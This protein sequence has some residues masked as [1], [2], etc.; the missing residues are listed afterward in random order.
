MQASLAAVLVAKENRNKRDEKEKNRNKWKLQRLGSKN[1][2]GN[3]S[4]TEFM[5]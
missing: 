3:D 5:L 4:H 1:Y 2:N